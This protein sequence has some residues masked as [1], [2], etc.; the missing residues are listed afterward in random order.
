MGT[1]YDSNRASRGAAATMEV[2]AAT[3]T[4]AAVR[5]RHNNENRGPKRRSAVGPGDDASQCMFLFFPFFLFSHSTNTYLQIDYVY[6]TDR[7]KVAM[8]T[9]AAARQAS[10]TRQQGGKPNGENKAQETDNISW[11][12]Y[13]FFFLS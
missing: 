11:A 9:R 5:R 1:G 4:R 8:A 2:A 6:R 12:M 7:S 10:T 3:A 13:K